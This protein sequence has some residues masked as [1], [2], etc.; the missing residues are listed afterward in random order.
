MNKDPSAVM[1]KVSHNGHGF[2]IY[3]SVPAATGDFKGPEKA[4]YQSAELLYY[5][6]S[7]EL[8][9]SVLSLAVSDITGR[10]FTVVVIS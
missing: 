4:V 7:A 9:S 1:E 10:M 5:E 2:C 8:Y 3:G 6:Y